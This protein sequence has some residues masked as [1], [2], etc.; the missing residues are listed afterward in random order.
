MPVPSRRSLLR[1]V[2][3]TLLG[4]S[5]ACA[6]TNGSNTRATPSLPGI[7][8]PDVI[9][10]RSGARIVRV[11]FESYVIVAAL[12]EVSPVGEA[13]DVAEGI[14]QLQTILARTYAVSHLGRHAAEGFDLCDTTHCQVYTP[15]RLE[16]SRFAAAARQAGAQTARQ[17]VTFGQRPAEALFHADCGGHTAAAE[18]VW[19]G[20]VAYLVGAAD[21]L[22]SGTHRPWQFDMTPGGLRAALN[23]N[24]QSAVGRNL[25]SIRIVDRDV[26]GRAIQIEL[27]GEVTHLLRGEQVRAILNQTYGFRAIRSTRFSITRED[28]NYR[29]AGTGFGHGVGVCQVGAA[30]RIRRGESVASVLATYYPGTRVSTAN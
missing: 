1:L 11:P 23:A 13:P 7:S 22:P 25:T 28:S 19:G 20:R 16:V 24:P 30:A 3:T 2:A 9:R 4:G 5:A 6:A 26:S 8:L 10:I 18:I 27:T 14:L 12:S 21:E 15:A 29:F 17:I